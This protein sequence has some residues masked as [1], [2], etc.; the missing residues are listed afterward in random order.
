ML[1]FKLLSQIPGFDQT[2]L[3]FFQ[4]FKLLKLGEKELGIANSDCDAVAEVVLEDKFLKPFL[5]VCLTTEIAD[6]FV[7]ILAADAIR[8]GF[9]SKRRVTVQTAAL[10]FALLI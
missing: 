6:R 9:T 7:E 2:D 3:N 5:H 8:L 1:L 10:D 4:F